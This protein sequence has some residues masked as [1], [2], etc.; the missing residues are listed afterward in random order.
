[1]TRR[2]LCIVIATLC[3]L[4]AGGVAAQQPEAQDATL[5]ALLAGP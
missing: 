1:M 4:L 5:K 3:C 2:S